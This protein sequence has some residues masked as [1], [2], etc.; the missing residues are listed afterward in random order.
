MI[1]RALLYSDGSQKSLSAAVWAALMM[2]ADPAMELTIISFVTYLAGYGMQW[3][4][5]TAIEYAIA[6]VEERIMQSTKKIFDQ[7][8]VN[9]R[10]IVG[11]SFGTTSTAESIVN[12]ARKG[13][14]NLIILGARQKTLDGDFSRL[15]SGKRAASSRGACFTGKNTT[16]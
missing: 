4:D 16:R 15:L 12:Y 7:H 2:T 5:G 13:N 9:A 8:N 3:D 6:D 14:F 1:T 11:F 10:T